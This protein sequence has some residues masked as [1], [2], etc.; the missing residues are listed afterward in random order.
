MEAQGPGRLFLA[1]PP[2]LHP[3]PLASHPPDPP[4]THVLDMNTA[5]PW[6]RNS[7]ACSGGCSL[8][9]WPVR[10]SLLEASVALWHCYKCRYE[11]MSPAGPCDT[12]CSLLVHWECPTSLFSIVVKSIQHKVY[13]F[14]HV[15]CADAMAFNTFPL[16]WNRHHPPYLELFS[17]CEAGTLYPLDSNSP[18]PPPPAPG[19]YPSPSL[20]EF[21][22]S[23]DLT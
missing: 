23:R 2:S 6:G 19:H 5:Q 8:I 18:A 11:G 12:Y 1:V 3:P 16:L 9:V 13:H 20:Y 21:D 17:F 4:D 22:C 15:R 14:S 7:E 10:T